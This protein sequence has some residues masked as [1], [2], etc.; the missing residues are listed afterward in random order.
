MS[1][2]MDN[3]TITQ[4]LKTAK[5]I[6]ICGLSPNPQKDSFLVAQYLQTHG[7]AITPIYPKEEVIL[8]ERVYRSLSEAVA[9][10]GHFDIV[11]AFRNAKAC[12]ALAEEIVSLPSGSVGAFWMQ[13]GIRSDEVA[14]LLGAHHI[15][16]IQ[17]KCIKI[18]HAH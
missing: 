18:E 4:L 17:D 15:P 5:T 2:S 10:K 3:Q 6:A 14:S 9:D 8:G 13:L 1:E 11:V 16:N 7:F 12:E